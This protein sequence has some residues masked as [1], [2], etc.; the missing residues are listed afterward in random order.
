MSER[1]EEAEL[2]TEENPATEESEEPV[3]KKVSAKKYKAL[4]EKLAKSNADLEHWRNEY[5]KAYADTQ[6]LRKSLREETLNAIKYRAEGFLSDLLPALDA[7]HMA[8][9]TPAPTPECQNYLIGFGYIYNQIIASL[10][11]EG[12][13]ELSP[14]VGDRFDATYMH[15][16]EEVESDSIE[17]GHLVSVY[18]KGYKLHDRLIRPARVAVAKAKEETKPET[19]TQPSTEEKPVNEA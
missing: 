10:T 7:F 4:E 11:N 3:G 13:V 5:Y 18:A 17:P 1:N 15:A 19:E 12:L 14:K 8:L 16:V 9:E 2:N 6:N